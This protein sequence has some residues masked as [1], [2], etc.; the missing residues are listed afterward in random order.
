MLAKFA[1]CGPWPGRP[2]L[3]RPTGP[4]SSKIQLFRPFHDGFCLSRHQMGLESFPQ[5]Y[6]GETDKISGTD[7]ASATLCVEIAFQRVG[8]QI[9]DF[10]IWVDVQNPGFSTGPKS[11]IFIFFRRLPGLWNRPLPAPNGL[12]FRSRFAR[13]PSGPVFLCGL[14][15]NPPYLSKSDLGQ[16]PDFGPWAMG[17]LKGHAY[18]PG[19]GP[20]L[21]SLC[22]A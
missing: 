2:G 1:P 5:D 13:A 12:I 9:L 18:S 8:F 10:R 14:A 16:I 19:V 4:K 22:G 3:A 15:H 6:L 17:P 20:C 11:G 7:L 21:L